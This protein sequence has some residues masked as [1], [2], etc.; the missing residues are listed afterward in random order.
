[1]SLAVVSGRLSRGQC[2]TERPSRRAAAAAAAA[3]QPQRE[4]A[5]HRGRTPR[6]LWPQPRLTG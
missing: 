2:G 6:P 1:M 3:G 5:G 4:P